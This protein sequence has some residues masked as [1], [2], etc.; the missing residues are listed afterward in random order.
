MLNLDVIQKTHDLVTAH[1][2]KFFM[3]GWLHEQYDD[4]NNLCGTTACVAGHAAI[5]SGRVKV[6]LRT[7]EHSEAYYKITFL[8]DVYWDGAGRKALGI[9]SRMADALFYR[10]EDHAINILRLLLETQDEEVAIEYARFAAGDEARRYEAQRLA[11]LEG[12]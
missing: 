10:H 2:E 1:P 8:D 5:I 3:G 4:D 11:E 12:A 7:P 9:S 6:D